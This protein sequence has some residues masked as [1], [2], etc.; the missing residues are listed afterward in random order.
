[1]PLGDVV[2]KTGTVEDAQIERLVA[3]SGVIC[4]TT[5]TVSV[6]FWAHWPAFGVKIYVASALVFIV[7]GFQVPEMPFGEVVAKTGGVL[8][9]HTVSCVTKFGTIPFETVTDSVTGTAHCPAFGVNT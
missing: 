9:A 4:E 7:D 5:F 1:M 3:K 2:D 6:A 8:P